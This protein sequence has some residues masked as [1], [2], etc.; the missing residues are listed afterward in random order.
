MD[1]EDIEDMFAPFGHV[2]IRR[3]FSGKG[4]YVDGRICAI[5]FGGEFLIKADAQSA[6]EIEAAGGVRW[7]YAHKKTGKPVNM[8]YWSMPSSA[9]D[10]DDERR[11]WA[12][13]AVEAA[14]RAG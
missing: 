5:D 9:Y 12:R 6:G 11:H 1:Q 8:P 3:M 14:G 4:V 7:S 10:D 2:S 13:L